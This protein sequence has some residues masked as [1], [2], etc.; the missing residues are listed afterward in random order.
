MHR[1]G[2]RLHDFILVDKFACSD[3][4]RFIAAFSDQFSHSDATFCDGQCEN[5]RVNIPG[6]AMQHANSVFLIMCPFVN[7]VYLGLISSERSRTFLWRTYLKYKLPSETKYTP[8]M[9]VYTCREKMYAAVKNYPP[10][11][12]LPSVL[13]AV[14]IAQ[15]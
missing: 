10:A 12:T 2:G 15:N 4:T 7:H 13:S 6:T 9:P 11:V 14:C 1:L 8:C 5:L 3:H